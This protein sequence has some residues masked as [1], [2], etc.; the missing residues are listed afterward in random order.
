MLCPRH[1]IPFTSAIVIYLMKMGMVFQRSTIICFKGAIRM[2][3]MC[4]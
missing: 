3:F 4:H 2:Q 1:I